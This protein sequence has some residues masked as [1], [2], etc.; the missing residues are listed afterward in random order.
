M[1]KLKAK[2]VQH[3]VKMVN[4]R[5][6]SDTHKLLHNTAIN[7]ETSVQKMIHEALIDYFKK[8]KL[9]KFPPGN[10]DAE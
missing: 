4:Y 5:C 6:P 2:N 9:G 1:S 8:H 10:G 3:K 7:R